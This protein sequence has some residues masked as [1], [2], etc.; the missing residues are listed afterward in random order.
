MLFADDTA[1][2][3]HTEQDLQY[4]TGLQR[5]WTNHQPEEEQRA[6]PRR[7]HTTCHHHRQL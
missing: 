5:L 4:L 1:V 6:R 7:G 3:S 2:T